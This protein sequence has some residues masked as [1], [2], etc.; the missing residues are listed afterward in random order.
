M[1]VARGW[2]A[3]V[4][5]AIGVAFVLGGL[6]ATATASIAIRPAPEAPD[7]KQMVLTS[8]D[9]GSARGH[10][11]AV[12]QGPRLPVRHL[13]QAR[14]RGR[15]VQ[16]DPAFVAYSRPRSG[17]SATTTTRY[18][19]NLRRLFGTKQFRVFLKES[20][21]TEL[22]AG[23]VVSNLQIGRLRN[24][25]A[26]PGSFD[27]PLAMRVLG[28]RTE[29]HIAAFRVERV[30]GVVTAMGELGRRLA[31][32]TMTRLAKIMA[33]RMTAELAPRNVAPPT[34]A[35]APIVGQSLTAP[36]RDVDT[37]S[38]DFTPTNG[39]AATRPERTARASSAQRQSRTR[40]PST[41]SAQ[42]CG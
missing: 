23:G 41:T 29:M 32:S 34:I 6:S 3:A 35:G 25:G 17:R 15:P 36:P 38:A 16:R 22:P 20:F 26:G 4:A 27:V 14:V 28:L 1:C 13:V 7:P 19:A 37:E 5:A 30:L 33:G 42:R 2:L 21:A 11:P 31:V 9:L 10:S 40:F 39:S 24:L 8:S 18:L 12:L